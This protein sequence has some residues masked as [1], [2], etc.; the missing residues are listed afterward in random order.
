MAKFATHSTVPAVGGP[1]STTGEQIQTHEDGP[2]W[3]R[4]AKSDLF[5]LAAVNMVGEDTFYEGKGERDKRFRDLIRQ[6]TAEDPDWGARFVP[7]LRD[8]MHM[9]SASVVMAAESAKAR[10]GE[11]TVPVRKMVAD[12][13]KRADEPGEF[14]A[15]WRSRFGRPPSGGVQRGVADA[16]VRLFNERAALKYDGTDRPWRLGDVVELVHPVPAA[17]WQSDLFR[18]M[19]DRRH[20]SADVRVELDRLP[21]ISEWRRMQEIP[22][23]ERREHFIRHPDA[24]R[25]AGMT[26]EALSSLGKMDKAV[27]EAVIPVMGY[28]A[29]LRNLRNF[30]EVG[31]SDEVAEQVA[32]QLADPEQVARSKQF[33]YRFLSAYKAAPSL[34]WGYALEKALDASVANVPAL[35]GRTLVLVDTSA[36]MTTQTVSKNSTI[37]ASDVAAL[38]GAV[39]ARRAEYA[40]WYG[41]ADGVFRHKVTPGGSVLRDIAAFTARTGEVGHGTR[42][43]EA[44]RATY[45]PRF[46]D[47]VIILTDMQTFAP[48]Y[49]YG[50]GN[51]SDTVPAHVDMFG[52][53]LAGYS[54]TAVDT[55]QPHRYEIGGFSDKLFTLVAMLAQGHSQ[56]WPF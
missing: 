54:S 10:A 50:S 18:W 47:R 5:L 12:A 46:H 38:F 39:L 23:A 27:W 44:V 36:S 2:A 43:V 8:E 40:E 20:H 31:V 30:D 32:K 25:A 56:G 9:R 24:L 41:F 28:M 3:A 42:M 34:R 11:V 1:V 37:H 55:S 14:L 29:C 4:D 51:V 6:V 35:P 33:P 52:I 21:V 7:F 19:L 45:Q 15:Y 16:A 13:L 49:Y 53:N 22:P 48:D 26:W 17:D